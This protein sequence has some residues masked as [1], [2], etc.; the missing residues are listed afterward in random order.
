MLSITEEIFIYSVTHTCTYSTYTCKLT[1]TVY[2][3]TLMSKKYPRD[4]FLLAE[5]GIFATREEKKK[6][7]KSEKQH[8]ETKRQTLTR[9]C[10]ILQDRN[11]KEKNRWSEWGRPMWNV[12]SHLCIKNSDTDTAVC[13]DDLKGG[14][15]DC[16]EDIRVHM[17][18]TVC[19]Y[20]CT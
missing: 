1:H 6:I 7:C 15:C 5:A 12:S 9:K 20:T 2:S 13:L 8:L 17:W 4:R 11:K 10:L 14:D 16:Y 18:H 19:V 3:S